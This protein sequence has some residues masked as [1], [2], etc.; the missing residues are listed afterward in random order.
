[1]A[2]GQAA[3]QVIINSTVPSLMSVSI[4][5]LC[6][7]GVSRSTVTRKIRDGEWK[8]LESRIE[9]NGGDKRKILVSSLP[10]KLQYKWLKLNISD[11]SEHNELDTADVSNNAFNAHEKE[12]RKALLRLPP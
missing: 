8:K 2:D 1:M 6:A 12:I 5:E 9:T 4:D 3:A 7:L 11:N 10:L